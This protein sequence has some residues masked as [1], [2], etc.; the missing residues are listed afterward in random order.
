MCQNPDGGS[1]N[2]WTGNMI[3]STNIEPFPGD[4]GM[5]AFWRSVG[6]LDL[7]P[8]PI[9]IDHAIRDPLLQGVLRE[10]DNPPQA[11]DRGNKNRG[12]VVIEVPGRYAEDFRYL[13][14]T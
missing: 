5:S 7:F 6:P 8:S 13:F 4:P 10:A 12:D 3:L 14:N 11:D 9:C 2:N 1:L